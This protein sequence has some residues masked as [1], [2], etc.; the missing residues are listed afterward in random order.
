LEKDHLTG[1]VSYDPENHS[2]MIHLRQSKIDAIADFIPEQAV[3]GP[4]EG[5]LLLVSWGG[6]CGAV[7]TAADRARKK[8]QS[9]AHAH[10]RYLNPLPRNL[11]A[12][13]RRYERVLVPELNLGQLRMLLRS[14][15]LIDAKGYNKVK[16]QPFLVS[17]VNEA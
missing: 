7:S 9:V 17:E 4:E 15:F 3:Q 1:N 12:L 14:R 8:G 6:T 16:G 10:L 11:E 2:R 5:D 13:M